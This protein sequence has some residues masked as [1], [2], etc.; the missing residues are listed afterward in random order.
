[1]ITNNNYL[2]QQQQQG[3]PNTNQSY[4]PSFTAVRIQDDPPQNSVYTL[5]DPSQSET[6]YRF[7]GE[8]EL[9]DLSETYGNRST[10]KTRVQVEKSSK[11]NI[12]PNSAPP[13]LRPI[14]PSKYFSK[15]PTYQDEVINDTGCCASP[16]CCVKSFHTAVKVIIWVELV[17]NMVN[18]A[19]FFWKKL[20]TIPDKEWTNDDL[21]HVV[22]HASG[23]FSESLL[24][25]GNLG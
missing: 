10:R 16:C 3:Y 5:T 1:M 6:N 17:R 14:S 23:Q 24:A 21:R 19:Q 13:V 25:D 11:Y 18:F 8:R 9:A 22:R 7:K 2:Q 20:I 4:P 12:R 15:E